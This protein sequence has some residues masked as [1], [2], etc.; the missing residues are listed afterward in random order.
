MS[1]FRALAEALRPKIRELTR[2]IAPVVRAEA[3][4]AGHAGSYQGMFAICLEGV[5]G[6]ELRRAL[7]EVER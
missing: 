3:A 6:Q 7:G 5:L 1:D 2:E 4:Q